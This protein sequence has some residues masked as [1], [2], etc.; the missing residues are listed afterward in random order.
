MFEHVR[1]REVN[2][3]LPVCT[4]IERMNRPARLFVCLEFMCV[5]VGEGCVVALCL[6]GGVCVCIRGLFAGLV[7][8]CWGGLVQ[9]ERMQQLGVCEGQR[10]ILSI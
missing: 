6:S 9:D 10:Y 4:S 2:V 5:Y 3:F 8:L 7:S 1:Q